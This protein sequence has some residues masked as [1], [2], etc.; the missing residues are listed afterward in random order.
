M[1]SRAVGGV[2]GEQTGRKET[3]K[4]GRRKRPYRAVQERNEKWVRER[5]RGGTRIRGEREKERRMVGLVRVV[6]ARG[7]YSVCLVQ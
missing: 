1:V 5:T 4:A 6:Q 3:D 2:S 7:A